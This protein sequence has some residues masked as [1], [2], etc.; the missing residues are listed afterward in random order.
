MTVFRR[1]NDDEVTRLATEELDRARADGDAEGEVGALAMLARVAVRLGHLKEG[2]AHA[3][4]AREVARRTGDAALEQWPLHLLAGTARLAGELDKARPLAAEAIAAH[5]ALGDV[6]M[7]AVEQHNLAHLELND[8]EIDRARGLFASARENAA[9]AGADDLLPELALGVAAVATFDG[10]F[11]RGARILG[12]VDS[13]L[14]ADGRVF[15]PDDF[16]EEQAI[17]DKLE[18]ALG[19][20]G[21]ADAYRRGAGEDLRQFSAR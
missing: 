2:W 8:G 16:L 6:R 4:Q 21:F 15:D 19:A 7:V 1:G 11:A 3:E 18:A 10:D 13:F 12:A 14:T 5:E 9:K 17:R 20:E